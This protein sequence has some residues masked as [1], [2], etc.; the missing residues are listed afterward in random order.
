M[1]LGGVSGR[2]EEAV[3]GGGAVPCG[4]AFPFF[5]GWHEKEAANEWMWVEFWKSHGPAKHQAA[6]NHG[7]PRS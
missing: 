1:Q 7:I 6:G 4:I 5:W 2:K 3:L